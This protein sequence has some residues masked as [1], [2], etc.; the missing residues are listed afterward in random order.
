MDESLIVKQLLAFLAYVGGFAA[1]PFIAKRFSGILGTLT[2]MV[3]DR[4]KGLIDRPRNFLKDYAAERRKG[5]R[6][7]NKEILQR[8]AGSIPA[9]QTLNPL[10]KEGWKEGWRTRR[11]LR[12]T[13]Q[14]TWAR[15]RAGGSLPR[16]SDFLAPP[17]ERG[18]PPKEG[19][20]APEGRLRQARANRQARR[21][22][23]DNIV[24]FSLGAETFKRSKESI[25]QARG[26][27]AK[28]SFSELEVE[29]LNEDQD[30]NIRTAAFAKLL[31]AGMVGNVR[32]VIAAAYTKQE[33]V[34]T[35]D[36]LVQIVKNAKYGDEIYKN[37]REKAPDIAKSMMDEVED[38]IRP[39]PLTK[40]LYTDSTDAAV[41]WDV[42]TWE[43]VRDLPPTYT[44]DVAG[45]GVALSGTEIKRRIFNRQGKG[46]LES[47]Q[48]RRKTGTL[49]LDIIKE[50]L[51]AEKEQK[52]VVAEQAE[53]GGGQA[54]APAEQAEGGENNN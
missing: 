25:E 22:T 47:P 52:E 42:K 33:E 27:V 34:G 12:A 41:Q 49:V 46:I 38:T 39:E 17:E 35:S 50:F 23:R 51:D 6:R 1:V 30:L 16:P 45:D 10:K 18:K 24:T 7:A 31:E 4:S 37:M 36:L 53:G 43:R 8:D 3:N 40:F 11:R 44:E 26:A 15:S 14:N 13:W 29:V 54:A 20:P 9:A 32:N 19:Q 28:K 5:R 21:K 2:G 48:A